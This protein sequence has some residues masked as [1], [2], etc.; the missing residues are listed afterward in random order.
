MKYLS[1]FIFLFSCGSVKHYTPSNNIANPAHIKIDGQLSN[2]KTGLF[3][4]YS[5][6]LH[7]GYK[8][9]NLYELC[10][11]DKNAYKYL[12][13]INTKGNETSASYPAEAGEKRLYFFS[14]YRDKKTLNGH[15]KN[16]D[17]IKARLQYILKPNHHYDFVFNDSEKGLIDFKVYE[18]SPTGDKKEIPQVDIYKEKCES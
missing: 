4:S 3:K 10:S 5:T 14:F 18:K 7:I 6:I 2:S 16:V 9:L 8:D 13:I 17:S 1:L 11:S 12:G 15:Y